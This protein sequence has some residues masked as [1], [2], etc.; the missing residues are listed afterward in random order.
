MNTEFTKYIDL[1]EVHGWI[2]YDA[3]CVACVRGRT[4]LGRLFERRGFEWVPLQT[5][6]SAARLG[7][8]QIAFETRMHLLLPDG[9]VQT[10]SDAMGTLCRTVWWL[11]PWGV[12]LSIPGFRD[13]GR[14][15]YNWFAR[16]RYCFGGRCQ[17]GRKPEPVRTHWLPVLLLPALALASR[18]LLAPWVFLWTLAFAIYAGFKWL[19]YRDA[20]SVDFRPT[21]RQAICYLLLWPGMDLEEFVDRKNPTSPWK[22]SPTDWIAPVGK[23]VLGTALVWLVVRR[24]PESRY[25][26]RGWIGMVGMIMMLHFGAFH[27]LAIAFQSWGFNA[28]PNMN[29][30]LRAKSLAGFWGRRWNTGF[31]ALADRYGF[32]PL[33]PILGPRGALIAVFVASGLIH[34]LVI[35]VPAGGGF[36]LPTLYFSLQALGLLLERTAFFRRQPRL[37]YLFTWLVLVIP[38]GCLFPP[39]F[40]R[41]VILPMLHAIGAT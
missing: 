21:R 40:V 24:I 26:L 2:F 9:R 3:E 7:V 31:N 1:N 34:D 4:R 17:L 22:L 28:R 38:L 25:L 33:K 10:N 19:T 18:G 8:D 39:V 20:I 30:P 35:A 11:W 13:L 32:R 15:I 5:P 36:G 37:K 14:L 16:R 6:G 27:L 12:L 41:N 29:A 23:I